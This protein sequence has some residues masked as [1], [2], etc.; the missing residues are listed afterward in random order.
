MSPSD[1]RSQQLAA[2][3]YH[4]GLTP[5]RTSDS[6]EAFR[7]WKRD[8]AAILTVDRTDGE[9]LLPAALAVFGSHLLAYQSLL[10]KVAADPPAGERTFFDR[11]TR[12]VHRD[13]AQ[14]LTPH[15]DGC[16][17]FGTCYHDVV[18]LLCARQA[19]IGG[20]TFLVDGRRLVE[21]IAADPE[22]RDLHDLIWNRV[23]DQ[24]G[25]G[26]SGPPGSGA[27]VPHRAPIASR[28]KYGKA[29]VRFHA[30][31]R[32]PADGPAGPE[33]DALLARWRE[34]TAAAAQASPR[35]LL[36]PGEMLCLDNF[37]MFHGR[38]PHQ[39]TDRL[40]HRFGGWSDMSFGVPDPDMLAARGSQ[41]KITDLARD[42]ATN[43]SVGTTAQEPP[44]STPA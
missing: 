11:D 9:A 32:L 28:T 30:D 12:T 35:F 33:D 14:T 37:R 38:E 18:L 41:V 13:G 16:L 44:C 15:V 1:T 43:T 36:Q 22:L 25:A 24:S 29:T 8:G 31:Q 40:L 10:W 42:T 39:G 20:E 27:R 17:V 3:P 21:A 34:I 6:A 5:Q 7:L 26:G 23:I 19:L 2:W 4:A